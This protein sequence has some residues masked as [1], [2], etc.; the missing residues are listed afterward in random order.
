MKKVTNKF[1][2]SIIIILT[3]V[4]TISYSFYLTF[5]WWF[6]GNLNEFEIWY[7]N[8]GSILWY[9]KNSF[10]FLFKITLTLVSI[11]LIYSLIK[12][13][14]SLGILNFIFKTY[15]IAIPYITLSLFLGEQHPFSQYPMYK[16][17]NKN[18]ICYFYTANDSFIPNMEISNT[19]SQ[20]ISK[21]YSNYIL[22]QNL[23]P[24]EIKQDSICRH[25]AGEFIIHNTV[26][27]KTITYNNIKFLKLY[28]IDC[29]IYNCDT[30]LL[31]NKNYDYLYK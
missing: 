4:L 9:V 10:L 11:V 19:P 20:F 23:L 29:N 25:K 1:I 15:F 6:L 16:E 26:L 21:Y 31:I 28:M 8:F 30:F 12:W 5:D 14:F 17:H 2:W 22:T 27:N 3:I 7:E 18:T 13:F 24:H